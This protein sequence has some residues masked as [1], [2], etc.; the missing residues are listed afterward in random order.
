M[1]ADAGYWSE[2]NAE[3]QDEHTEL[4]IATAK[5]YMQRQQ[6][7]EKGPPRGR[8]PNDATPRDLMERKLLT[9][10][11][12]A[13]YKQRGSTIEPSRLLGKPRYLMTT[14]EIRD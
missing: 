2:A 13:A 5:D 14:W 1:I 7:E 6:F 10:R 8:I 4:F 9:Q 11:G 12:R 3:L